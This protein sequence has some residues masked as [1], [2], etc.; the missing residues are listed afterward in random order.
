MRTADRRKLAL[1]RHLLL[2]TIHGGLVVPATNVCFRHI[3]RSVH[4]LIRGL[5]QQTAAFS[6][7]CESRPAKRLR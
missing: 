6:R 2:T 3:Q 7:Y 4:D 5:P 1:P